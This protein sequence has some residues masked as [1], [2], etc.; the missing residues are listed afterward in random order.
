MAE[1]AEFTNTL[2]QASV[3]KMYRK[4]SNGALKLKDG[5]MIRIHS[6]N[7]PFITVN[8][9]LTGVVILNAIIYSSTKAAV[10]SRHGNVVVVF[11]MDESFHQVINK[12]NGVIELPNF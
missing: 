7:T 1:R 12:Y 5:G 10:H 8:H 11:L 9:F 2:F 4:S 6:G 3:M